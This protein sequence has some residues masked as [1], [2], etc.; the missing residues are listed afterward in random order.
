MQSNRRDFRWV[1]KADNETEPCTFPQHQLE[2]P[3]FGGGNC[4]VPIIWLGR[5]LHGEGGVYTALPPEPKK[6]HWTGYYVEVYFPS[7]TGYIT[8]PF[9]FT[10]PGYAWPN[11]LPF[12]P[13]S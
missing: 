2:K 3:V 10:T 8:K 11:T 4:L 9:Q 6:G 13:C 7:D 5:T 1:R 12:Q